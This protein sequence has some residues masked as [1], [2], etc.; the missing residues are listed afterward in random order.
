MRSSV[1]EF[2]GGLLLS[3]FNATISALVAR[4]QARPKPLPGDST[5]DVLDAEA[6]L[7]LC[8]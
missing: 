8:I 3:F 6:G 4:E 2:V 7:Q 5:R 1:E